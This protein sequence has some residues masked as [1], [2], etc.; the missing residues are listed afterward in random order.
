MRVGVD[1]YSYHRLLGLRR[2]DEPSTP[3]RFA[4]GWKDIVAHAHALGVEVVALQTMFLGDPSALDVAALRDAVGPLELA[5]SWGGAEGLRMGADGDAVLD[6]E[7]WLG[8]AAALDCRLVRI[9]VG[10][11]T[12][13]DVE[14]VVSQVRR[15]SPILRRVAAAA[16]GVG[17]ELCVENHGDLTATEL[18]ELLDRARP[19]AVGVCFDAANALRL[20]DDVVAAAGLLASRI[21]MVHL[22]DCDDPAHADPIAGPRVRPYGQ[23]TVPVDAVLSALFEYGFDGPVCVE[24]AQLG[25]GDDELM[26]VADCVGWLRGWRSGH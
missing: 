9:V 12:L 2:P 21:R 13:R 16:A 23:G 4:P 8:V 5:L 18:G 3:T 11:P 1:S 19:E 20:G 25:P 24:L 15:A 26:L 22:R 10:G 17:V 6:L 7:A 14:P